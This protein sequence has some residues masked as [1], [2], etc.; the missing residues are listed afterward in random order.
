MKRTGVVIAVLCLAA[1]ATAATADIVQ[2]TGEARTPPLRPNIP[3]VQEIAV[4]KF[5]P[6]LG[7][8]L[9]VRVW[10]S[11]EIYGW[12]DVREDSG[13]RLLG[14]PDVVVTAAVQVSAPPGA[15]SDLSI[16]VNSQDAASGPSILGEPSGSGRLI[17]RL[18]FHEYRRTPEICIDPTFFASYI[19]A[20]PGDKIVLPTT[21]IAINSFIADAARQLY[22]VTTIANAQLHVDYEYQPRMSTVMI[23]EAGSASLACLGLIAGLPFFRRFLR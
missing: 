13:P 9:A 17:S 19:A 18:I 22:F 21:S 12:A 5:D 11:A 2:Q 16:V 3:W 20:G 23:P 1:L 14:F 4:D 10:A 6:A 15:G 8:L 7:E